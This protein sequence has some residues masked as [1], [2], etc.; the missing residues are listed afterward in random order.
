MLDRCGLVVD[1]PHM[2][3]L[4]LGTVDSNRTMALFDDRLRGCGLDPPCEGT[5]NPILYRDVKQRA[6][7]VSHHR[8]CTGR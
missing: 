1:Y 4:E 5:S 6:I 8:P 3:R 7:S 2:N